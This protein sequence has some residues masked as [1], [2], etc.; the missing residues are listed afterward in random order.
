MDTEYSQVDSRILSRLKDL[1]MSQVQLSKETGLST[2]AM[3]S[4]CTGKRVPETSALYRLAKALRTSMEWILTGEDLTSE[5][6]SAPIP[7]CDD[8]PLQSEEADLI[9][10]FR[11]L[12]EEEREDVFDIVH[13]KYKRRVERKRE[14]IYWTYK[15]DKLKQKATAALDGGSQGVIA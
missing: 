10:M 7:T 4:Y 6:S 1:G 14:S 3:S 9:A 2:T 15:A 13:L 5:E 12:P 8:T 11:L